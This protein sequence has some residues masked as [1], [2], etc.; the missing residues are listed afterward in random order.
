MRADWTQTT[1]GGICKSV[2]SASGSFAALQ[3]LHWQL[4]CGLSRTAAHPSMCTSSI[5][6]AFKDFV[7]Q[8]SLGFRIASHE[9]LS[10]CG[11]WRRDTCESS[12]TVV[13]IKKCA[14]MREFVITIRPAGYLAKSRLAKCP[15]R[16]WTCCCTCWSI[17]VA[18]THG[19]N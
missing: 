5:G 12:M 3:F 11:L 13:V 14:G 8:P 17:K 2:R 7:L 19:W 4:R 9:S 16:S 18:L 1:D 10:L 6:S 15:G